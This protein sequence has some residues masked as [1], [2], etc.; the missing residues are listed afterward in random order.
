MVVHKSILTGV[1]A[2][3]TVNSRLLSS[4]ARMLKTSRK[5]LWK[6]KN[7]RVQ[8][9]EDNEVSCWGV[10][11]RKS[12]QDRLPDNVRG[13]MKESWNLNSR[14][15]P[16]EK[17][18]VR[19]CILKGNYET[20]AKHI[21]E[22]TQVEMFKTFMESNVDAKISLSTFVKLKPWY[23]RPIFVCDTCCCRYHVEFKLYYETFNHFGIQCCP[24]DP[25]LQVFM[26]LYLKYY[27]HERMIKYSIRNN[28]SEVKM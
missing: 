12:Y 13:R 4:T 23:V 21:I 26:N 5:S 16:N 14:V 3:N 17:D 24:N 6:H 18:V 8:L 15:L 9:D 2:K 28:A 19:R 11:C 25:L 7:F 22:I 10:T 20:H 1:V 27:V